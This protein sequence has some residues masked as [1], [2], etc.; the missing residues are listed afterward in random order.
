ML[1]A[2]RP[3]AGDARGDAPDLQVHL[4]TV[5]FH[6]D[7]FNPIG[8]G[9]TLT[10]S[11]IHPRSRGSVCLRDDSDLPLIRPNYL[12]D[13]EGY[14]LKLLVDGVKLC[15]DLGRRICADVGATEV[16]PGPA[17]ETDA[18]VEDYVRKY[19][20]TMYHPVG[21]CR[22]GDV[23][24]AALRVRGVAG[25]RV[26]D[27]SVMPD[28]VGCNTNAT[29]VMI[30]E[31]R[32]ALAS[33]APPPPDLGVIGAAWE[34]TP[35]T[36]DF[37]LTLEH[38][39]PP[40]LRIDGFLT[41]DECATCVRTACRDDVEEC[42]EY[43]NNRVNTDDTAAESSGYT[44]EQ[45]KEAV[46]WSGGAT[47]GRR[48]RMPEEVLDMIAPKALKLL[49]L[50]H[51]NYRFAEELYYRP[52][53]A[54]VLIRDA[55]VV[56]YRGGEGVAPHVDGKDATLLVYLNT[57]EPGGG[58]RTV[59]PE[60]GLAFPPVGGNAL[61]YDSRLD[62]LHFA[63]PVEDGHEQWILQLLIDHRLPPGHERMPLVDWDTGM[64]IPG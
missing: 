29:C 4:G 54:T 38:E 33:V 59:F 13:P 3:A 9:F 63:E 6:P 27:A 28:I 26:A 55:T 35:N 53:R 31:R 43:L 22:M 40:V 45:A 30:G 5:F 51:R 56:R 36:D 19:V 46:E 12:T 18:D 42:T 2:R 61:L 60:D 57:V 52:D 34:L 14:D 24:D 39:A 11:L 49:G 17:V 20:S 48:V 62:L 64:I 8:E 23:V 15:R 1:R 7:G 47:S 16:H 32:T 41:S 10:P 50:E 44:A 21:T 37:V 58:G 25:L